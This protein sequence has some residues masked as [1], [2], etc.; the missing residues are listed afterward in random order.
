MKLIL[1]ITIAIFLYCAL[2]T[3]FGVAPTSRARNLA[4]KNNKSGIIT[5]TI[6]KLSKLL[7]TKI[8]L[9]I[10]KKSKLNSLLRVSNTTGTPEEFTAKSYV[11]S[12]M[13]LFL[14]PVLALSHELLALIPVI[15]ALYIPHHRYKKLEEI[16]DKRKNTIEKELIKFVMYMASAIKSEKNIISCIEQYKDNFDTPLTQELTYTL[17]DMRIGSYEQALINM[18]NRNHSTAISKLVQGLIDALKGNDMTIYFENLSYELASEWENR[19]R[20]QALDQEPKIS[21]LSLILFG[22]GILT[23]FTVLITGLISSTTLI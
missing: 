8:S 1:C 10:M 20:Q 23:V 11:I 13:V 5:T 15:L 3:I 17:A 19:L 18:N 14:I 4:A 2:T 22:M 6:E 16:A 21:R 9:S 12:I 7:S